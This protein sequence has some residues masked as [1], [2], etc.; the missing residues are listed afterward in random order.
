MNGSP[1]C[2][3]C[4]ADIS[5][6]LR[7]ELLARIE[8]WSRSGALSSEVAERLRQQV[9][10]GQADTASLESRP[11]RSRFSIAMAF[12]VVGGILVVT[13]AVIVLSQLW[14]TFTDFGRFAVVATPA[15]LLY[16]IAAVLRRKRMVA[17]WMCDGLTLIGSQLTP[18][19]VWLALDVLLEIPAPGERGTALWQCLAVGVALVLQTVTAVLVRSAVLTLPSTISVIWLAGALVDGLR[20][21]TAGHTGIYH[22]VAFVVA[23]I[24]LMAAGQVLMH[25]RLPRHA[26]APNLGGSITMLMGL[27]NLG[28]DYKRAM[29]FV[30]LLTPL[31]MILLA[32]RDRMRPYLWP[33]AVFLVVNIF[34]LGV[35]HFRESVGLPLTLLGCGLVSLLAGYIVQRVQHSGRTPT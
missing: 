4:G 17:T 6:A 30:A 21:A 27:T 9:V 26:V 2:P 19:V 5:G 33:A 20:E 18:F 13:A 12:M 25:Y 28:T 31:T 3:E 16:I 32:S 11:F 1:T 35:E 23:G 34:V 15:V 24:V 14:E 10:E 22:G 7:E 8:T 29:S